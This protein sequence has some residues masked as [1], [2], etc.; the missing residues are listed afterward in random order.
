MLRVEAREAKEK[1]DERRGDE[2][3]DGGEEIRR[4]KSSFSNGTGACLYFGELPGKCFVQAGIK[5]R[6]SSA[7]LLLDLNPLLL[8]SSSLP[9]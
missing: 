5:S 1:K 3:R 9:L 2:D 4:E 7:Q 8:V 6:R